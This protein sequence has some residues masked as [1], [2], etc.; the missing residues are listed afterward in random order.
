[1]QKLLTLTLRQL[2]IDGERCIGLQF[3]RSSAIETLV[4]TLETP[5]WSEQY[6]MMYIKNSKENFQ[7]LFKT[8]T[9]VAWIDLRYFLKNRPLKKNGEP[10]DLSEVR[11]ANQEG[12]S[13]R[14]PEEYISL[15][16][17]KRYSLNTARTYV[18]LFNAFRNRFRDKQLSEINELDIRLYMQEIVGKGLS[19]SYQNQ[20]IN[21]IKF[22][23]EQVLDMPQ[24]FYEIERPIKAR[25][26]P[27]VLSE[28]EVKRMIAVTKNIKHKAIIVTIYSCGLRLSEL[29][30]LKITD[31]ESDRG[32][33]RIR[34]GK[35][36]KD[37]TT[38]LSAVTLDLLRRYYKAYKP[39]EFLFE[40]VEGKPYAA[41]SVHNIV[42]RALRL[43]NIN[44]HASAHTLR[45]SFATH[46]LENGTDLRY[47]QT[48][49]G[50]SSPKTTEIYAH[51]STKHLRAIKSPID[52]LDITL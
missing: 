48:L 5:A 29:L 8:F 22:Y 38:V 21:A 25:K 18:A 52:N 1:M 7:S 43:A 19:P 28:E 6:Q 46:L 4:S 34:N 2:L 33:V 47:I 42:K 9:G 12:D 14:C 3:Q 39:C 32:V 15:L 45:H 16:E 36:K 50:H 40:G 10:V 20:A 27:E 23:Y 44:R 49:L 41:K 37:R 24:R 51:V 26:L 17:T 30:S 11:K 13:V 35:G 31:V